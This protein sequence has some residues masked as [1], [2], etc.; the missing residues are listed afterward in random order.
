LL[1]Q[2]TAPVEEQPE[3]RDTAAEKRRSY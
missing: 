1:E 3:H 2:L